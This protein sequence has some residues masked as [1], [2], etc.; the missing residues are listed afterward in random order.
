MADDS[1]SLIVGLVVG[2]VGAIATGVA[3]CVGKNKG[4]ASGVADGYVKAGAEYEEKLLKQAEEFLSQRNRMAK[5]A[6]EKDRIIQELVSLLKQTRD[7]N[8]Q[9]E[10]Q[11]V[12]SRVR[13]A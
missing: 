13:A 7:I 9:M 11:M 4:H 5:S 10:I 3:W 12:L 1:K 6:A 8:R 2:A